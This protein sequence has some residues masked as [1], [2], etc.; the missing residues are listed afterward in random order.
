[1]AETTHPFPVQNRMAV[2][3]VYIVDTV[4]DF[5]SIILLSFKELLQFAL[6]YT[7]D[8]FHDHAQLITR[9]LAR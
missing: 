9:T 8:L 6:I 7:L 5:R 4:I 1:M 2:F 3:E